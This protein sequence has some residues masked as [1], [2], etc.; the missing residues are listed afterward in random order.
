MIFRR[1]PKRHQWIKGHEPL[2]E[3]EAKATLG[4]CFYC[5]QFSLVALSPVH[6]YFACWRCW[7]DIA[8]AL[9]VDRTSH[10]TVT[11]C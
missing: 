2:P 8:I 10:G 5:D 3:W 7:A 9:D 1:K 6:D 11:G 4:W